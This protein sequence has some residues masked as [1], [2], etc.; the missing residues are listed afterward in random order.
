VIGA[1][2]IGLGFDIKKENQT[3]CILIGDAPSHGRSYH[4]SKLKD[5]HEE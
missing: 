4:N 5:S 2:N 3:L 1:L